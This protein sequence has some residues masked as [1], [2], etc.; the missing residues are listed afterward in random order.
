MP[1]GTYAPCSTLLVSSYISSST[2][3]PI[4]QIIEPISN[5]SFLLSF[6]SSRPLCRE[7]FVHV[8]INIV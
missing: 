8:E 3:D 7:V 2:G 1:M 6:S 4:G 5:S